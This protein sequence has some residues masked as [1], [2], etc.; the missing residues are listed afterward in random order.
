[1]TKDFADKIIPNKMQVIINNF[2][3]EGI[4]IILYVFGI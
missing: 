1:M 4:H 3:I 2:Y